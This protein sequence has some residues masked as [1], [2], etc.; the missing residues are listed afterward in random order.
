MNLNAQ[1][2]VD[3]QQNIRKL[4]SDFLINS[5][6][7]N[8][9]L[10]IKPYFPER[11]SHQI[12]Q[13]SDLKNFD[14]YCNLK[15]FI[16]NYKFLLDANI[17]SDNT[18]LNYAKIIL[19][20]RN[21]IA[22][23]SPQ[24]DLLESYEQT[25]FEIMSINRFISLL[26][27]EDQ[28]NQEIK[29]F[30]KM[31]INLTYKM[32]KNYFETEQKENIKAKNNEGSEIDNEDL[33]SIDEQTKYTQD[34]EDYVNINDKKITRSEALQLLRKLRQEISDKNPDIPKFRNIL[35][36]SIIDQFVDHKILDLQ[37]FK[38]IDEG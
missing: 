10:Y 2:E 20:W 36:D 16:G 6:P 29:D 4:L 30:K 18:I 26:P 17:I 15:V 35:R 23:R 14:L 11:I 34:Q 5:L 32:S 9:D 3:I 27:V 28:N 13:M 12:Y 25:F 19:N 21:K 7:N 31:T 1:N 33:V 37:K 24:S 8:V 38:E 22:H